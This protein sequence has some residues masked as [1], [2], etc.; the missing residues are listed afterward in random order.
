M[1]AETAISLLPMPDQEPTRHQIAKNIKTLLCQQKL[2]HHY[3]TPHA[4]HEM[5]LLKQLKT[6]LDSSN[7]ILIKADKGNAITI[8]YK[9]DYDKKKSLTIST[10]MD[11]I[12]QLQTQ[13]NNSKW[14]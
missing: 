14:N 12:S 1:E 4:H 11:F 9:S 10:P 8:I 6:K 13:Q 5:K 2:N 3:N 7:A